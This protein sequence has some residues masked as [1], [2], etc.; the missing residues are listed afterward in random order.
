MDK[1]QKRRRIELPFDDDQPT[2]SVSRFADSV[3]TYTVHDLQNMEKARQRSQ[4]ISLFVRSAVIAL[5]LCVL[6]YSAY[7]II[8]KVLDNRRAAA[9]YSDLRV[10]VSDYTTVAHGKPLKEP[11]SMPTVLQMLDADGAY[12]DYVHSGAPESNRTEHYAAYYAN[13]MSLA[14]ANPNVYGWIYMSDTDGR[15][16]Y[17]IM[18]G[19]DNAYYL[20][21][22]YKG[23]ESRSGSIFADCTLSGN[24]YANYN[25]VLYGH[26]MKDGSMFHSVKAWCNS[27]KIKTLVQTSQIEIYTRDG[28]YI[29]D[30]LSYYIDDGNRFATTYFSDQADYLDFLK[31]I[32]R[33]SHIRTNRAYTADSRVC[34]LITC[35]NGSDGDSRYVVHGILNHFVS[36]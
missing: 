19:E 9:A 34:T 32:S 26:N 22:N 21:H 3:D 2:D 14:N 11:N 36:F 30:I 10:D 29:Y 24:F 28:L 13:F 7:Q 4:V 16:D 27:A 6:C 25:M 12:E 8:D 5:C 17:P 20:T 1:A 35:T 23:E 31:E 33:K 18:K 15:V